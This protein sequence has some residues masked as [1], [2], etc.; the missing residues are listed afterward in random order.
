MRLLALLS[1]QLHEW[2]LGLSHFLQQACEVFLE[3]DRSGMG[4]AESFLGTIY[5][6]SVEW[7]SLFQFSL[8]LV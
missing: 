3:D 8:S 2:S 5:G 1:L 6:F 4:I 7:L